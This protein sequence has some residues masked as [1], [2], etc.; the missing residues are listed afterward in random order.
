MNQ[1]SVDYTSSDCIRKLESRSQ[2]KSTQ[3]FR[4]NRR[5]IPQSHSTRRLKE[6]LVMQPPQS[7]SD[8]TQGS[9]SCAQCG[10]PMP[11][12]M[13]F[14]R[15]CGNRLGEGPA[16]YTETVRFADPRGTSPYVP[17]VGAPMTQR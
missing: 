2:R 9:I 10:A 15:S 11:R 17:G 1:C 12:E 4:L 16:E 3:P 13:R 8:S 7:F 5:I 6:N 14:C